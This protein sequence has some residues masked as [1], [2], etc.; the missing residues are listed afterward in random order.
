YT[1]A[2]NRLAGMSANAAEY[3][4]DN[5]GTIKGPMLAPSQFAD[6]TP[7]PHSL[8]DKV[9]TLAAM[10]NYHRHEIYSYFVEK[11]IGSPLLFGLVVLGLFRQPWN[12][13][14]LGHESV[15]VV[16]AG[17]IAFV[18]A[19]SAAGE[20]RYF[21]PIVPLLLLWASKGLDELRQWTMRWEFPR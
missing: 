19:T 16:M 21:L 9:G 4:I 10:A 12:K 17:S 1:Q 20:F 13:R 3:A 15:L 6:G 14:R 2:R 18:A 11:A 5:D 7:Y 8:V